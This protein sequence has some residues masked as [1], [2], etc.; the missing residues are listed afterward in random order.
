MNKLLIL[1]FLAFAALPAAMPAQAASIGTSTPFCTGGDSITD[2]ADMIALKLQ[3][4]GVNVSN[5]EEWNG[6]VRA[7]V[8]R[9]DGSQA[10]VYFDPDT[11]QQIS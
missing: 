11:L 1:P 8:T 3:G 7:Y 4:D 10:M 5:V 6:C 9:N 2:D